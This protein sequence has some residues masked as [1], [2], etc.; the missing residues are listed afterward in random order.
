MAC[1]RTVGFTERGRA[2]RGVGC[3]LNRFRFRRRNKAEVFRFQFV[4]GEDIRNGRLSFCPKGGIILRVFMGALIKEQHPRKRRTWVGGDWPG[5]EQFTVQ[6][7]L[8]PQLTHFRSGLGSGFSCGSFRRLWFFHGRSHRAYFGDGRDFQLLP[9]ADGVALQLVKGFKL[10]NR[11]AE[12]FPDENEGI[13]V[14]HLIKS[15]PIFRVGESGDGRCW[16]RGWTGSRRHPVLRWFDVPFPFNG[17]LQSRFDPFEHSGLS[18]G[19]LCGYA[20]GKDPGDDDHQQRPCGTE[21]H[22]FEF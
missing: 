14:L 6:E 12:F 9:D 1:E 11:Q 4:P 5:G 21:K 10:R 13:A 17:I 22:D 19:C 18:R 7:D 8:K 2:E 3:C 16:G 20:N 15:G